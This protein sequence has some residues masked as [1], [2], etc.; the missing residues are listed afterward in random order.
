MLHDRLGSAE[1]FIEW[2]Q[3]W[4]GYFT[5][6]LGG[7][8]WPNIC[9]VER[10]DTIAPGVFGAAQMNRVMNLAAGP[11]TGRAVVNNSRYSNVAVML[12]AR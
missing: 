6:L 3:S 10:V 1:Q 7:G 5:G 4:G 12:P 9:Q 2:P 8:Q 11:S